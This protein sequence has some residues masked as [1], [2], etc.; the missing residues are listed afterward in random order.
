MSNGADNNQSASDTSAIDI[1]EQIDELIGKQDY[2]L[3]GTANCSGEVLRDF[4]V[5]VGNSR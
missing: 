2:I 3:F 1:G 5:P 4:D